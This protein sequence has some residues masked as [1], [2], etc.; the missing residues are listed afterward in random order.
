MQDKSSSD[1]VHNNEIKADQW[2]TMSTEQLLSQ[3]FILQQ[4]QQM[5]LDVGKADLARMVQ[6]GINVINSLIKRKTK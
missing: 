1:L 5:L 3:L 4:R 2:Q 6:Q